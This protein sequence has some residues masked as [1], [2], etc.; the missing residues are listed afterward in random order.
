MRPPQA[1]AKKGGFPPICNPERKKTHK[2]CTAHDQGQRR[3]PV[4]Q[5]VEKPDDLARIGHPREHQA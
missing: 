2:D 4:T 5:E 1:R 3:I